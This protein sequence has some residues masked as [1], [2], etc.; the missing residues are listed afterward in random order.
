VS[1]P[2]EPRGLKTSIAATGNGYI[3]SIPEP[4]GFQNSAAYIVYSIAFGLVVGW[5]FV[6]PILSVPSPDSMSM[7]IGGFFT[8]AALGPLLGALKRFLLRKMRV[9]IVTV[10][11]GFFRVEGR[12][13]YKSI[14]QEIPAGELKD[15]ILPAEKDVQEE[16]ANSAA[17][18]W[19]LFKVIAPSPGI[20]AVGEK[21]KV[22]FG[23]GLP[24][25]EL[26]YIRSLISKTIAAQD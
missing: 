25:R 7:V 17:G 15:L 2:P 4:G 23:H 22:T 12:N 6:W 14:V 21:T 8:L 3:M 5:Y 18:K 20:T 10:S 11:P 16:A 13:G 26:V 24:R 1:I 9:T 19:R